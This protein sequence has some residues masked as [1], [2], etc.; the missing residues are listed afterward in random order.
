MKEGGRFVSSQE[1]ELPKENPYG[2]LAAFGNSEAKAITLIAMSDGD[3]YLLKPLKRKLIDLQGEQ[4]GWEISDD[5][6]FKYC[7]KSLAPDF[8][9]E[10]LASDQSS[11][12]YKIKKDGEDFGIPRAGLLL[13]WSLDHPKYSLYQMFARTQSTRFKKDGEDKKRAPETRLKIFKFL[14]TN[15]KS[16]IREADIAMALGEDRR[17]IEDHLENLSVNGVIVYKTFAKG[18]PISHFRLQKVV[19]QKKPASVLG[20][21]SLTQSIYEVLT[22]NPDSFFSNEDLRKTLNKKGPKCKD[23]KFLSVRINKVLWGLERQGYVVHEKFSKDFKSQVM[24]SEDQRSAIK[25]LVNLLDGFLEQDPKILEEGRDS[26]KSIIANPKNVALLMKKAKD[27]SPFANR[28]SSEELLS[29]MLG[30]IEAQPGI[31]TKQIQEE[32]KITYGKRL[33]T[34]RI[35][36][37]AANLIKRRIIEIQKTKSGN[38]YIINNS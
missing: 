33:S 1:R 25:S 5:V 28:I 8:V 11:Y 12:G 23:S 18:K 30:I 13:K 31:N 7:E 22:R 32:I 6:P 27:A 34:T 16:I 35:L 20:Y 9:E 4:V 3:I 19:P 17:L 26:A 36:G 38:S 24:L 29:F 37:L 14:L 2:F 15:P 21:K 10:I